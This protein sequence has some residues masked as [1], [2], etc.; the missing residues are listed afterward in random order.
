MYKPFLNFLQNG[1]F[2]MKIRQIAFLFLL[3]FPLFLSFGQDIG[4]SSQIQPQEILIGEQ[5]TIELK[6]RTNDLDNTFLIVPPDSAMHN[7]EI[8]SLTITDTVD[9]KSHNLKEITAHLL[10][11]SFDSTLVKIPPLGV[12]LGNKEHFAHPLFLKV[13]LPKVDM[14]NVDV[15]FDIK[16]GWELPYTLR[17]IWDIIHIWVYSL[18]LILFFVLLLFIF[19]RYKRNKKNNRKIISVPLPYLTRLHNDLE[20]IERKEL[21]QKGQIRIFYSQL[22]L[23]FREYFSELTKIETLEMTSR[24]MKKILQNNKW[25]EI[26]NKHR[27][28]EFLQNSDIGKFAKES[29]SIENSSNDIQKIKVFLEDLYQVFN[30]DNQ[31]KEDQTSN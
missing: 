31:P 17:E 16:K 29:I 27:I 3:F 18:L 25:A 8:L 6:I 22:D 5:A 7:A 15:F 10:I 9:L 26:S 30:E 24:Q 1:R 19:I 21:P 13:N 4:I 20:E 23:L 2:T 14:K 28:V 12:K 11:T